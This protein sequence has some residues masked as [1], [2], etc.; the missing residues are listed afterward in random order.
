MRKTSLGL[1]PWPTPAPQRPAF[2]QPAFHR[3]LLPSPPQDSQL[4]PKGGTWPHRGNKQRPRKGSETQN[5]LICIRKASFKW[6]AWLPAKG[7]P[8]AWK[9]G[10]IKTLL[11]HGGEVNGVLTPSLSLKTVE[12]QA[13]RLSYTVVLSQQTSAFSPQSSPG[14]CFEAMGGIENSQNVYQRSSKNKD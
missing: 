13:S 7:K 6:G 12:P 11:V 10:V 3:T 8:G 5:T 9:E 14:L 4:F 1:H 2:N